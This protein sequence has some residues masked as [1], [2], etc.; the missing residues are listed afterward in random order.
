MQN[1]KGTL[2]TTESALCLY[3]TSCSWRL[4]R[5]VPDKNGYSNLNLL[6]HFDDSRQ[7][8]VVKNN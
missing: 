2:L 6:E 7:T 4:F 8:A 3:Q 5:N 1:V